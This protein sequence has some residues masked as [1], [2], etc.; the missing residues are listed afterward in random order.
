MEAHHIVS[1]LRG[2]RTDI[3]NLILL[4]RFHHTLVHDHGYRIARN[5]G[6][7]Q[8]R[9]SDGQQV[10]QVGPPTSGDLDDL[11]ETYTSRTL[12]PTATLTPTWAGEPLDPDAILLRLLPEPDLTAAA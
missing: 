6:H 1:W 3:T 4:C 8:F 7:L 9:R 2:G 12:H 11:V 10:P 5:Q